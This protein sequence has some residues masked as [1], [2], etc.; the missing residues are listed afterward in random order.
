MQKGNLMHQKSAGRSGISEE[1]VERMREVF[2][3][4]PKRSARTVSP[5]LTMPHTTVHKMLCE[6][7]KFKAYM[8]QL[9]LEIKLNGWPQNIEFAA[10]LIDRYENDYAWN[11][12]IL[13][14]DEATFHVSEFLN[15]HNCRIWDTEFHM[16]FKEWKI[17]FSV[18]CLVMHDRIFG[19]L[20]FVQKTTTGISI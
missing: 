10:Y 5:Q 4:S 6:L 13:Y 8:V 7:L 1:N 19:P 3:Q 17:Q 15:I 18:E 20:F 11:K 2:L 14:S 9:L 16:H 12:F